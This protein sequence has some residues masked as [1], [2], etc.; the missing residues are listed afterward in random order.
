M[1]CLSQPHFPMFPTPVP[2][3]AVRWGTPPKPYTPDLFP[4]SLRALKGAE[5]GNGERGA[6]FPT[7][8]PR[9]RAR[10]RS[11]PRL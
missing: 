1:T 3:L 9:C 7:L 10:E 8:F 4:R 5:L 6:M 11:P 2:V